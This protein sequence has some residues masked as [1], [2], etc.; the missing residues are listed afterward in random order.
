[1][2]KQRNLPSDLSK[3]IGERL[4]AVRVARGYSRDDVG[5][6]V[7]LSP[8]QIGHFERGYNYPMV[9]D[10]VVICQRLQVSTD[11]ILTG[12][13]TQPP[14]HRDVLRV[15]LW[16]EAMPADRR[17]A[18]LAALGPAIDDSEVERRIPITARPPALPAP[19]PPKR[20]TRKK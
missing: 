13:E 6:W 12:A 3:A 1:M 9:D 7:S 17:L 4:K 10:L 2:P 11:F 20:P 16:L 14:L 15:A 8:P 5:E 19:S 18:L